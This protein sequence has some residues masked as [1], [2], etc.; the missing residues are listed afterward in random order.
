MLMACDLRYSN[1]WFPHGWVCTIIQTG[2]NHLGH[3]GFRSVESL[4]NYGVMDIV[5]N[6][7]P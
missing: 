7:T 2:D 3:V 1:S 5:V 4:G 6:T